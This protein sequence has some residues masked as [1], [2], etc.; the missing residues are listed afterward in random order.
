MKTLIIIFLPSRIRRRAAGLPPA[1]SPWQFRCLRLPYNVV[2]TLHTVEHRILSFSLTLVDCNRDCP[3][4]TVHYCI[5]HATWRRRKF[6]ASRPNYIVSF[7]EFQRTHPEKKKHVRNQKAERNQKVRNQ[8]AE[9][10]KPES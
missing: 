1:V 9:S 6:F 2:C 5:V 3:V 4:C 7:I 8:K 10:E